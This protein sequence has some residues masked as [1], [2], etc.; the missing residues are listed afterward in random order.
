MLDYKI[1][2]FLKVCETMN[3]TRAADE[4][5]LTQP[6]VSRHIH[7]LEDEYGV[8]L[9][10]YKNKRIALTAAGELLFRSAT[11]MKNDDVLLAEELALAG[12]VRHEMRFGTTKTIGDF[13]VIKPFYAYL[14]NH[15]DIDM[16]MVIGNT[17]ELLGK[18]RTGEINFALVEGYFDAG[19]FD[20]M[21]FSTEEFVAVCSADHKFK[22]RPREI[23]DLF[24]ENILV[25]EPGSGTRDILEKNL[26]A[27]NIDI[28]QFANT[29]EIGSMHLILQLVEL[30]Y[31]ISFMYRVAA[32]PSL[33]SGRLTEIRLSD[34]H[35][36]HD[37]AFIWNRGSI[38]AERYRAICEEF[39]RAN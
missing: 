32:A 28:S 1:I 37:F 29:I 7:L 8:K 6:A 34:F 30:G 24:S 3:F 2:T 11:A 23:R 9:F 15:G 17:E 14:Q 39:R 36:K 35:V 27:K 33:A 13:S 16:H 20:S 19:E 5:G 10:D 38:N 4:L 18:L 25:R 26:E 12:E 21:V 31:G 22:K